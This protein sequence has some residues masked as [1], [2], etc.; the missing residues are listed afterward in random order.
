MGFS[1]FSYDKQ[2]L[3]SWS[4]LSQCHDTLVQFGGFLASNLSTEDYI[5]LVPSIDI[6]CNQFHTPHD[7]A[8]FLSRPMYAHQILVSI[9]YYYCTKYDTSSIENLSSTISIFLHTF[10]FRKP[11]VHLFYLQSKYD[12]LKKAEKGNK[13]QQKLQKYVAACEQ[14]MT[15][16]HES[17]VSLHPPRV[18]DDLRPQFYATFWSLTMYDLAVPH[19][20]Y[21][22]EVNK[23]KTQI[24]EIEE[25]AEMVRSSWHLIALGKTCYFVWTCGI[26]L[27]IF[28]IADE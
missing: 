21:E 1:T 25:N 15:P 23:L 26:N 2:N 28:I 9:Y 10:F 27:P 20:A 6:L 22:R 8:F 17:V 11:F 4:V 19:V 3:N 14:V 7:A 12:E 24:R 13:Q 5:K 16:V 18:W